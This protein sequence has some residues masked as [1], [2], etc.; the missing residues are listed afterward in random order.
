MTNSNIVLIHAKAQK[1]RFL[2]INLLLS[3]NNTMACFSNIAN[4]PDDCV[5]RILSLTSPEDACRMLAVS[6]EFRNPAESNVVWD[7]FLPSDCW[8]ILSSRTCITPLKFS[9]KKELFFLL[10]NSI[11]VDA[12]YK[13]CQ[14]QFIP[15]LNTYIN[16]LEKNRYKELIIIELLICSIDSCYLCVLQAFALEKST[17]RKSY[18]LSARELSI[19][20]SDVDSKWTWKSVQESRFLFWFFPTRCHYFF[21]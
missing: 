15:L 6:K 9:S 5:S 3:K 8:H 14:S 20:H 2:Q 4:L 12:G 10:S 19:L 7:K 13:V 18:I 16:F 11:L 17:G 1:S 21:S